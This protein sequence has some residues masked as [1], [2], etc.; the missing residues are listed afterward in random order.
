MWALRSTEGEAETVVWILDCKVET[1]MVLVT[2]RGHGEEQ[3]CD[4]IVGGRGKG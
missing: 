3:V 2:G 1:M 4:S